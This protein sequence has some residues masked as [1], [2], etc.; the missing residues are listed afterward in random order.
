MAHN[1]TL[2]RQKEIDLRLSSLLLGMDKTYPENT[3]QEIIKSYGNIQI[4]EYD[5]E[6]DS[7]KICG[8]IS[9]KD[10]TPR[11]FIN[12]Q[13]MPERKTFTLAHEFGHLILH[14][15]ENKF[16]LDFFRYDDSP[17]AVQESE[18]NY[19]AASLLM[20]KEQF[21]SVSVA[22]GNDDSLVA[23]YFGVSHA[24]V[25]NRRAWIACN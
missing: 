14:G 13:M 17:E 5:F 25:R 8:A 15:S 23:Q 3:L 4:T 24:A 18:A 19:F 1:L 20:P 7:H 6:D 9:Y 11:I 22:L 10:G 2:G 16:R 21:L 12:K